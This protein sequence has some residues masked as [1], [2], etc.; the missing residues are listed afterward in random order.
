MHTA[1][2]IV[3]RHDR[4]ELATHFL[5]RLHAGVLMKDVIRRGRA[6]RNRMHVILTGLWHDTGRGSATDEVLI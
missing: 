2:L 3:G 1:Q 6:I 5:D 4:W